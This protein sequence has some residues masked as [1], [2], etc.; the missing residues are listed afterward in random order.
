MRRN[1]EDWLLLGLAEFRNGRRSTAIDSLK[2]AIDIQPFRPDLH[3]T[4]AEFY[5][6]VGDS[7]LARRHQHLTQLLNNSLIETPTH[8]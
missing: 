4:L 2:K 8:H 3:A 5:Q 1:S 7:T 6:R